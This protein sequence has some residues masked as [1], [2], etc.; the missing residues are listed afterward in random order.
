MA[1][2]RRSCFRTTA[3]PPEAKYPTAIEEC[4]AVPV[5]IADHGEEM[6][7]DGSRIAVAGDS[8]GGNMATAM[9]LMAKARS[10]PRLRAQVLF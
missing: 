6:D 10:G 2:A 5:W 7:L 1:P 3:F 8:V 9:T 4:Y